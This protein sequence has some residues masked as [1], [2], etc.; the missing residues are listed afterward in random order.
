[1]IKENDNIKV[2]AIGAHPDDI[3]IGVGMR[4]F[5]HIKNQDYVIGIIC[6]DGEK[7]GERKTRL[8]ETEQAAEYMGIGKLYTLHFP[9][10]QL[11]NYETDIKDKIEE[12]IKKEN[13]LITYTPFEEDRHQDHRTTAKASAIACRKVPTIL[14]YKGPS[15]I[16][17]TFNPHIFHI[18]SEKD[19]QKK[20]DVLKIHKSQVEKTDGINLEQLEIDSKFYASSVNY[21]GLYAEAF[22]VNHF[23]LNPKGDYN[24]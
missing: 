21:P 6:S 18:G 14:N 8:K 15:T 20:R 17:N 3:E 16:Y 5:E 19:F 23:I 22:C 2:V 11:P 24:D 1:M 9:D 12:I 7:G 13:P 10:T 4:L